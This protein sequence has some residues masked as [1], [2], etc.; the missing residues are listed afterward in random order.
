MSCLHVLAENLAAR[1]R[2]PPRRAP[3]RKGRKTRRWSRSWGPKDHEQAALAVPGTSAGTF[4]SD[5]RAADPGVITTNTNGVLGSCRGPKG[6]APPREGDREGRRPTYEGWRRRSNDRPLPAD[7]R[8]RPAYR[9]DVA[10]REHRVDVVE[11]NPRGSDTS[12]HRPS[13][14]AR[15]S[16]GA[17]HPSGE[18][19]QASMGGKSSQARSRGPRRLRRR[20][21]GSVHFVDPDTPK[22]ES[23]QLSPKYSVHTGERVV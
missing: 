21:T 15:S 6:R 7:Q 13:H 4:V 8:V 22:R 12:A 10:S 17:R 20:R 2:S 18:V 3:G 19:T 16:S 5:G 14:G 23:H 11:Q 9:P 1:A